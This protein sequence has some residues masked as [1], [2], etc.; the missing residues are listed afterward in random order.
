MTSIL[1]AQRYTTT[2]NIIILILWERQMD[3]KAVCEMT[4][5]YTISHN[6]VTES[7]KDYTSADEPTENLA[8]SELTTNFLIYH[9]QL[10]GSGQVW[11][12]WRISARTLWILS[13][14]NATIY[15]RMFWYVLV[16]PTML[17]KRERLS[18]VRVDRTLLQDYFTQCLAFVGKD[19]TY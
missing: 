7:Y 19:F 10:P 5:Y 1:I 14:V 9:R 16:D 17:T 8:S 15:R 18:G 4:N 3:K 12:R 13:V 2:F 11:N 6:S